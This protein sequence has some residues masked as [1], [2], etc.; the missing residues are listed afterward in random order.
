MSV[1]D[2]PEALGYVPFAVMDDGEALCTRCVSD[3]SNPV[4]AGGEDDGWRIEGWMH[5]GEVESEV[6][7]AHCG[8]TIVEPLD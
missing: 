3:E 4:H 7:C 1:R 8:R 6:K 2:I 5:S